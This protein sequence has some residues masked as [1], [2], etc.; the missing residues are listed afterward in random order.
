MDGSRKA[1]FRFIVVT[2]F[3]GVGGSF[4]SCSLPWT[5]SSLGG[6]YIFEESDREGS[7]LH[8]GWGWWAKCVAE[9]R[10]AWAS[11][12]HENQHARV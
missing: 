10:V 9:R 11:S 3:N 1:V 5:S 8:A 7:H 6:L 4:D 2:V 12:P